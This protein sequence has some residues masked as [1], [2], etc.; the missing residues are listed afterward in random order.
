MSVRKLYGLNCRTHNWIVENIN[1]RLKMVKKEYFCERFI[2]F[3][4]K[5]AQSDNSIISFLAKRSYFEEHS[6]FNKNA[7][8]IRWKYNVRVMYDD[9]ISLH[10][11]NLSVREECNLL[12]LRDLILMRDGHIEFSKDC[13]IDMYIEQLSID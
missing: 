2:S 4:K 7:N 5:C 11:R 13:N 10:K 9:L 1:E 12:A 8:Y 3:F 6:L